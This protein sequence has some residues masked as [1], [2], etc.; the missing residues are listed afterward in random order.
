MFSRQIV[1][2][3]KEKEIC[4]ICDIQQSNEEEFLSYQQTVISVINEQFG[5]LKSAMLIR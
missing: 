2:V 5:S 4:M 3:I 1:G